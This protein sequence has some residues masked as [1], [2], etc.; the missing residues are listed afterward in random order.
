VSITDKEVVLDTNVW[1][2]GLLNQLPGRVEIRWEKAETETVRK[3]QHLGCKL[4]DAVLAAHLEEMGIKVLATES[5]HFLEEIKEV[6]FRR[7]NAAQAL[8]ELKK[9]EIRHKFYK[10]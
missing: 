9:C 8:A 7:I 6:P 1:I 4:G 5:R 2:F 3:Y 10:I